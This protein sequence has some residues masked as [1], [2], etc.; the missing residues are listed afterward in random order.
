MN[1]PKSIPSTSMN[2]TS[3]VGTFL[4][5]AKRKL[6]ETSPDNIEK[7]N[8]VENKEEGKEEVGKMST[9]QLLSMIS[10]LLD[11]KLKNLPTKSDLL[12][13]KD[14]VKE[15]KS[16]V[17]K[18]IEENKNL[19]DEIHMLK[20]NRE[21]DQQRMRRLEEDLGKKKLIIKGLTSQRYPKEAVKNMFYDKLNIH[22]GV[23]VEY[24]KKIHEK[25]EKMSVLVE[26]KSAE[27]VSEVFRNVK[28]LR[29]TSIFIE[30]DL[31]TERQTNK[32]VMLQLKREFL[33]LNK[34]KKIRVT[35]DKLVIDGKWFSW[36]NN[37]ILMCGKKTGM[38]ELVNIFGHSIQ[39]VSLDFKII[40]A[41]I[42]SKNF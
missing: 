11:D 35:N 38:E 3:T 34:N 24:V 33:K 20:R 21:Q 2:S 8:D 32:K 28:K 37:K 30:R 39:N 29:G 22:N 7:S 10:G 17:N 42:D 9:N 26:L 13:V 36:N 6:A 12:E 14:N 25:D 41:N 19:Q 5:L 16:E 18:L 23:E 40:M 15:V 31:C 1:T 4:P 27:M